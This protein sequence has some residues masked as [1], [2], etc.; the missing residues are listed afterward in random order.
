[1][2]VL[3]RNGPKRGKPLPR[4]FFRLEKK[5]GADQWCS[6]LRMEDGTIVSSISEICATCFLFIIINFRAHRSRRPEF[7]LP[8]P[9]VHPPDEASSSCD[10]LL[11]EDE[12]LAAVHGMAR[13]KAPGIDGLPL[14][15]YLSFWHL[16]APDLLTVLNFSFREGHF[17][18]S[19]RSG[20]ITLLLATV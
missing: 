1:M 18:I 15:F 7:S 13:G 17:P 9:R 10:G 11:S 6:A 5:R 16:L 12:L 2:S 3:M 20:I 19:L 4:Y 14:E 8:A